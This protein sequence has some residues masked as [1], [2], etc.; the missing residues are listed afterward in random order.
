MASRLRSSIA[1]AA[2]AALLA[3]CAIAESVERGQTRAD[4]A[5]TLDGGGFAH[6]PAEW[7]D[8]GLIVSDENFFDADAMTAAEIDRF[9]DTRVPN[10][11]T[12]RSRSDNPSDPGP[13]YVCLGER[14]WDVPALDVPD[15]EDGWVYCDPIPAEQDA[16][17]GEVIHAVAVACG[18]SPKVLLVTLEKEQSLVTDTWAWD[19]QFDAAMG[20]ACYDSAPCVDAF[21]GFV[22]QVYRAARAYQ[23]YVQRPEQFNY[24]PFSVNEVKLGP[25][26]CPSQPVE[27]R[28]RATAALYDY[29][30]YQPN[31]A[32]LTGGSADD[33]CNAYGNYN[34]WRI[35]FTWFGDPLA[36]DARSGR[37]LPVG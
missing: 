5:A 2:S 11:D 32:I 19:S 33:G 30:P 29:T 28:N 1:V 27:I 22:G 23:Q 18:I 7:W 3:G 25:G 34:F 4:A 21:S 37:M 8:A 10:C 17:A 14:T 9:I 6:P 15:T 26:E 12:W 16:S 35:W 31:A 24:Q 13:P 36:P 20:Y